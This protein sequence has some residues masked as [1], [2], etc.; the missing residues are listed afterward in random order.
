MWKTRLPP[1]TTSV[2]P[3]EH[4]G[5]IP[6]NQTASLPGELPQIP[7]SAL[8]QLPALLPAVLGGLPLPFPRNE[9]QPF[10][11][12]TPPH[13]TALPRDLPRGPAGI[14]SGKRNLKVPF[15]LLDVR[16]GRDFPKELGRQNSKQTWGGSATAGAQ[17]LGLDAHLGGPGW[18]PVPLGRP[19]GFP[20]LWKSREKGEEERSEPFPPSDCRGKQGAAPGADPSPNAPPTPLFTGMNPRSAGKNP[21]YPGKTGTE[22]ES[23]PFPCADFPSPAPLG[24]SPLVFSGTGQGRTPGFCSGGSER[25]QLG[26]GWGCWGGG[27]LRFPFPPWEAEENSLE[28]TGEGTGA[29]SPG[30]EQS[31]GEQSRARAVRAGGERDREPFPAFWV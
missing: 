15:P 13:R 29:S 19:G 26:P 9:E 31:R 17:H 12:V 25:S 18:G 3:P 14:F 22:D 7:V 20:C 27:R 30:E 24:F 8:S 11:R 23:V 16:R 5:W 6:K 2:S 1:K 4:P 10:P 28:T 21:V